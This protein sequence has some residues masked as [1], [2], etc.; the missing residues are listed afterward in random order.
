MRRAR[1]ACRRRGHPAHRRAPPGVA[2][3]TGPAARADGLRTP[4]S[5]RHCEELLRRSNPD[6]LRGKILDCFAALAMTSWPHAVFAAFSPSRCSTVSRI[7]NFWILPV[8][9][10]GNS[11][12]NST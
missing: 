9:V 11:S 1:R 3:G 12:T 5:P 6:C 2:E 4:L 8:T 10:I 7:T